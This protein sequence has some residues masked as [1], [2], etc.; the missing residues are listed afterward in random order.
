MIYA[1]PGT[2]VEAYLTNALQGLVGTLTFR[3]INPPANDVV[4]AETAVGITEP[5]P[6]TYTKTIAA[7]ATKGTYLIVWDNEGDLSTEVLVVASTL[8]VEPGGALRP[9]LT[10][11]GAIIRAYT[12]S[13][14][15]GGDLGTFDESTNPTADQ[16]EGFI[17]DAVSEV[18]LRLPDDL[19][20]LDDEIVP[21]A[22][23]L[24]A[25]RAAMFVIISLQSDQDTSEDS[26]YNRLK[27]LYDEGWGTLENK[28]QQTGKGGVTVGSVPLTSPFSD[29]G[30]LSRLDFDPFPPVS[31]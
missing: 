28:L 5:V 13:D 9:E 24:A 3:V 1:R 21:F 22:R 31:S 16:V 10:E 11:V 23:R 25:I 12:K 18:T 7:P 14:A 20:G 2:D 4:V 17:T 19:D 15:S 6:G 26:A 29:A 27:D 8:P 30:E